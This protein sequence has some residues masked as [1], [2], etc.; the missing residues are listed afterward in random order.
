MSDKF[1]EFIK[2]YMYSMFA[3][4][5]ATIYILRAFITLDKTGK[6]VWTIIADGVLLLVMGL[7]I[8][9]L[10]GAQGISSGRREE[11]VIDAEN[12]HADIV[13][14]VG[15]RVTEMQEFCNEK[16]VRAL[17]NV[18]RQILLE[19]GYRYEDYF[20]E[21][22]TVRA[23]P[24]IDGEDKNDRK[25][26][27]KTFRKAKRFRV[28]MLSVS[29]LTSTDNSARDPNK[30]GRAI[31]G[32]MVRQT[33]SDIV[34]KIGFSLF[35]GFYGVKLIQDVSMENL[36]YTL[37]Q[38]AMLIGVGMMKYFTSRLYVSVEYRERVEAKN[39]LLEE[40]SATLKE[41]NNNGSENQ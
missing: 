11:S 41:E 15:S 10:F 25:A 5:I 35:L 37:L 27:K 18:R 6:S 19:G 26:R 8:D 13:R 2:K 22:G 20:N 17:E 32:F 28:T 7:L 23:F 12:R 3:A 36:I 16:N 39:R 4:G 38:A 34:F 14:K 30:M 24:E 31:S 9:L 21:D 33:Q 40:F 1:K 29:V